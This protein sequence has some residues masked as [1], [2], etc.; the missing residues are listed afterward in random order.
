MKIK[1]N[2]MNIY[3][4][5]KSYHALIHEKKEFEKIVL[6]DWSL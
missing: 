1:A 5:K 3:T 2:L 6:I 4:N